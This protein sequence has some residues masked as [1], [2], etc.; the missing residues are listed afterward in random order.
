MATNA[1]SGMW[2]AWSVGNDVPF[3]TAVPGFGNGEHK[4]ERE[5]SMR[6]IDVTVAGGYTTS[7]DIVGPDGKWEVKEIPDKNQEIRVSAEGSEDYSAFSRRVGTVLD[8]I[9]EFD[10][11][12]SSTFPGLTNEPGFDTIDTFVRNT[13]PAMRKGEYSRGSMLGGTWKNKT[14]LVQIVDMLSS[15][16]CAPRKPIK[17]PMWI[18]GQRVD[19]VDLATRII[20]DMSKSAVDLGAGQVDISDAL[21]HIGA[22]R[23]DVA[24]NILRDNVFRHPEA[25]GEIWSH[26]TAP[27]RA[28][29][30]VEKVVAVNES[31]GFV[32]V[33]KEDV[34]SIF[35]FVRISKTMMKFRVSKNTTLSELD[36]TDGAVERHR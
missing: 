2:T 25:I 31:L 9:E 7:Y 30:N 22:S 19:D 10:M 27:S 21:D 35:E 26:A 5:M 32:I 3:K 8:Q 6:D 16:V 4:L 36:I 12:V 33:G 24:R 14:G 13:V 28:F 11:Y 20:V 18:F 17:M 15:I 29:R 23:A 1:L 34:D